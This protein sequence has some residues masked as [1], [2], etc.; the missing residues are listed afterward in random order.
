MDNARTGCTS[1]RRSQT[2]ERRPKRYLGA[3]P[4][5]LAFA[6]HA[7]IQ[8]A[9][10]RS[11]F[12]L[13][14]PQPRKMCWRHHVEQ[15]FR[16]RCSVP[17]HRVKVDRSQEQI[18]LEFG[19][20][21]GIPPNPVFLRPDGQRIESTDERL[22]MPRVDRAVGVKIFPDLLLT[23]HSDQKY[24]RARLRHEVF[25]VRDNCPVAISN[26]SQGIANGGEISTAIEGEQTDH[27]LQYE[28]CGMAPDATQIFHEG[29]EWPERA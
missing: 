18:L 24:A 19:C 2:S 22:R 3:L 28:Q 16:L 15:A 8:A 29:Q 26:R 20:S 23:T 25:C 12:G 4:V 17:S 13:G 5:F 10:M 1:S 6:S 21:P 11:I 27:I 9:N 7:Q 14:L